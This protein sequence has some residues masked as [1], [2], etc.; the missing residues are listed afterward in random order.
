[1]KIVRRGFSGISSRSM[2]SI[3]SRRHGRTCTL[4]LRAS[5][6]SEEKYVKFWISGVYIVKLNYR[7]IRIINDISGK[8]FTGLSRIVGLETNK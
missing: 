4:E 5:F 3:S 1:M 7:Y 6:L 8:N 2:N